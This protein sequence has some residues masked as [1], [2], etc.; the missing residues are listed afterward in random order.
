M[1]YDF[2][3]AI[4]AADLLSVPEI[5][6]K[7]NISPAMAGQMADELTRAGYLQQAGID[8]GTGESGC[9]GCPVGGSCHT[10]ARR[11]LLTEKGMNA[12]NRAELE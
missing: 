5:A 4:Q 1:L 11:W 2:L 8:C 10:P 9:T 6:H 12:A 7:L 3:K